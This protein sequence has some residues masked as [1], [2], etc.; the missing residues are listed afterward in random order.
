MKDY[1]ELNL[2]SYEQNHAY[3]ANRYDRVFAENE[4][5]GFEE[6]LSNLPGLRILDLGCGT[7]IQS[8][9]F[10]QKGFEVTCVDFSSKMVAL[11]KSKD[12]NAIQVNIEDL[13]FE[14]ESFD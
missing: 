5:K 6:F 7:G 9:Y 13:K 14:K 3:L 2:K 4:K 8:L 11:C 10:K 1:N 12:L